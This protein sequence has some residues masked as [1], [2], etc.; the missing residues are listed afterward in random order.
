MS[1]VAAETLNAPLRDLPPRLRESI[2]PHAQRFDVDLIAR[3]YWLSEKAHRGQKRASGEEYIAHCVEVA[4]ILADLHL[5]TTSV[6]SGLV[7]DVVEDTLISLSEVREVLGEEI[8]NIVD[9]VTKIGKVQFRSNT[10]QQVENYR[11][12]LLSM[13]QDARVILIKLADRVHNMRTLEHLR[14]D[15]RRRIALETREIYAPLAHR[16]GMARIR[17]ELEDLTFKHLEPEAYRDLA[18]KVADRRIEREGNVEAVRGPLEEELRKAGIPC[19][20]YGRPKHLWSIH[21]KMVQRGKP[22]EEIYDL[23]AI[24][25]VTD[26]VANCYHALGVIHNRWTPL[27][28]RFHDYIA[29]PKSNMYRSLHTTIFGQRGR[30]YEIQIRTHEMHRT[31]EYGIAAHWRYKDG[32]TGQP[33]EVDEKLSWFR[34]VLE[35]QQDTR[36]P[37]EFMEFLRIDLFQDEIFVFT[38]KGDVKQ[39]PKTSTPIDFAFAVHTEVGLRCAG[40]RVNGRIAP[41]SR[42][43]KNGDTVEVITDPRHRPSRDWLAFVKTARAR[44]KI[45]QWI[46]QEESQSSI[47]LGRDLLDRELRKTRK[48]KPTEADMTRAAESLGL[49]TFENVL[50]ALG[51]GELGPS[52]ILKEL[53]PSDEVTPPRPPTALERLVERMRGSGKGVRIQGLENMMVRYSACCQPVPGDE[54]IGYITRGRGISI[55]RIDCPNILNLGEHPE[56]RVEIEW[57]AETGERFYVRLVVEGDDRRGLLSDIATAISDT[58]TNIQSAEIK[59]VE[60]GMTGNFAVEVQDLTH[61][62]KVMKGIR[63]VKGVLSVER[64]E[65]FAELDTE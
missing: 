63:R 52:A 33:N 54:V 42:E 11:K 64:K 53:Y 27:Q 48:V 35:W 18:K 59:S 36:E 7:H 4:K 40:A 57:E 46:K 47:T 60:G 5:D 15:K 62:K 45:R 32:D 37:E 26:N 51:R 31:A 49:A 29:T 16:L 22:Y 30:L 28:E 6:A 61:L 17:W 38:P 50:S 44:Q 58:G 34:Q 65:H 20:V 39:L 24:R 23:M 1:T 13:A 25:V 55:H 41:L 12:L 9:G 43:L 3:A 8:A 56:R 19:E 10:E 14:A 21:R 2:E